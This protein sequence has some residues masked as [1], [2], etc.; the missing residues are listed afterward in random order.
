[1]TRLFLRRLFH[2]ILTTTFVAV[3]QVTEE[4]RTYCTL[5]ALTK[6]VDAKGLGEGWGKAQSKARAGGLAP[7][8]GLEGGLDN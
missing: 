7:P 8:G 1:M 4:Y 5:L 6:C 3:L 2:Y